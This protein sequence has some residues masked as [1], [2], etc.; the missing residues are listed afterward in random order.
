MLA[1]AG[2]QKLFS[3]REI[4]DGS[5]GDAPMMC[6]SGIG[7]D[8]D[9]DCI[10][11]GSDDCPGI[12]DPLQPDMDKD[13]IGDDCDP[14]PTLAGNKQLVFVP[15]DTVSEELVWTASGAWTVLDDDYVNSDST[16]GGEDW[17]YRTPIMYGAGTEL[18]A[19][20]TVGAFMPGTD[21]KV[22]VGFYGGGSTGVPAEWSCSVHVQAGTPV[23]DAY[24]NGAIGYR[25]LAPAGLFAQGA[26]YTF[27][28]KVD[29][30]HV[31]CDVRGD[32]GDVAAA[33]A[34]N[35][36]PGALTGYLALYTQAA[37]A[38]V[39]YVAVYSAM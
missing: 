29:A 8:E 22:G 18:E 1:L 25:P 34:M 32:A 21:V 11:D 16:S 10:A 13:T 28:M 35:S 36:N 12:A 7:H 24:D 37:G 33:T 20:I 9:G 4:P 38:Q 19:R 5:A 39:H 23:A 15:F 26:T 6:A 2:C 31:A 17:T 27:R 3:L 30:T 14:D